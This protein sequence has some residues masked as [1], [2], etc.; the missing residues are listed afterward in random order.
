[1]G[2]D[3]P[4]VLD[5]PNSS[6]VNGSDRTAG[7]AADLR[8]RWSGP[9]ARSLGCGVFFRGLE[10]LHRTRSRIPSHLSSFSGRIDSDV[11][12]FFNTT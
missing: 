12:A 1:M 7:R 9:S 6:G 5:R 11:A 4:D 8:H 3:P 10:A 2:S